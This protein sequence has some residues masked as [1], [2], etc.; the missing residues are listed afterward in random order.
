MGIRDSEEYKAKIKT[1]K[2]QNI[3]C[4]I[5]S[6]LAF[7]VGL[8]LLII[9]GVNAYREN[10]LEFGLVIGFIVG[11]VF[12]IILAAVSWTVVYHLQKPYLDK[13]AQEEQRI[14]E[15]ESK[16]ASEETIKRNKTNSNSR[17]KNYVSRKNLVIHE[18]E[19]FGSYNV[20][21]YL[22]KDGSKIGCVAIFDKEGNVSILQHNFV[23]KPLFAL[24]KSTHFESHEI[25]VQ[26]HE[27]Y[28]SR[29]D[30]M[31]IYGTKD[32]GRDKTEFSATLYV[33]NAKKQVNVFH[34]Q[35]YYD[36]KAL[37]S[38][39]CRNIGFDFEYESKRV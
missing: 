34:F 25:T 16:R 31:P 20:R 7:F 5:V 8:P 14:K 9:G 17:L 37:T 30:Y 29:G 11:G 39:K 10:G 26:T 28:N 6:I 33:T 2:K 38:L 4:S 22:P 27:I 19:S 3:F 13:V 23:I 32:I 12:L 18:S 21:T 1:F 15:A 35:N 24:N 36:D